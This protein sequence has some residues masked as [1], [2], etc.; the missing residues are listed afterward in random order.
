MQSAYCQGLAKASL[1]HCHS[2]TKKLWPPRCAPTAPAR[3]I[4]TTA[5]GYGSRAQIDPV[6]AGS[7]T[8]LS[9]QTQR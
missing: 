6:N 1:V 5:T 7:F 9:H 8:V 4:P 2:I 3:C